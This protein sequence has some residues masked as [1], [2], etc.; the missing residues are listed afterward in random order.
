MTPKKVER[1]VN[2]LFEGKQKNM[3]EKLLVSGN[4]IS[5]V[6]SGQ[7]SLSAES[8]GILICDYNIDPVWLFKAP[9]D[10]PIQYTIKQENPYEKK[11]IDSLESQV[12]VLNDALELYKAQ[13]KSL[14]KS[15]D[16][17]DD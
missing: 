8:I 3:A 7:Q 16:L 17:Y 11:Y 4:K 14:K 15:Q 9:D 2:E 1:I 10:E 13:S 6:I 5:K 12:S